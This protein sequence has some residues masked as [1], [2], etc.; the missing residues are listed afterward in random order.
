MEQLLKTLRERQRS[1]QNDADAYSDEDSVYGWFDSGR[2]T[3]Y[4]EIIS[5]IMEME[6]AK[7]EK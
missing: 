1:A 2:A 5:L 3:A 6:K 4:E 7:K